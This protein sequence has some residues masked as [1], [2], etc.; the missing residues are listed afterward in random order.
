M[1]KLN[2]ASAI[3]TKNEKR[4]QMYDTVI[5]N[6]KFRMKNHS[7]KKRKKERIGFM[8]IFCFVFDFVR[9]HFSM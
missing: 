4:E 7:K 8:M 1:T 6:F 2:S 9:K 5:V 3:T